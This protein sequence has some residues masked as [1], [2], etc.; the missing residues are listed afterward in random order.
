MVNYRI[1]ISGK[2][3]AGKNTVAEM[4]V[5][6]WKKENNR[7]V[8]LADPMKNIVKLMFPEAKSECL[9][10]ASELRSQIISEKYINAAGTSLTYR[11]ALIDLGAHGRKYHKNIWLNALVY[12]ALKSEDT[13]AYIVSDVR[14]INEFTYLKESG[15]TMIRVLRDDSVKIDDI[16]EK[17]QD[18]IKDS[19]FDYVIRNNETLRDLTDTVAEIAYTLEDNLFVSGC[20]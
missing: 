9:W 16:S 17:E 12:D 3:R 14:F 4:F 1:A 15:F 7:I 19:E 10:G 13:N 20:I 6:Y 8:A 18:A 11:E 2:A 5:D